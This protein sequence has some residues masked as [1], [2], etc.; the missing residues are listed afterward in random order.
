M[1]NA[2]V[3]N[4]ASEAV[5]GQPVSQDCASIYFESAREIIVYLSDFLVNER[6]SFSASLGLYCKLDCC[7]LQMTV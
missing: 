6:F 4:D 1:G 2:H 7:Q 5:Y 3:L